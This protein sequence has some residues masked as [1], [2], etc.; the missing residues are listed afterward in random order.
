MPKLKRPKG[1]S[2]LYPPA[3]RAELFTFLAENDGNKSK[4]SRKLGIPRCTIISLCKRYAHEMQEQ[5]EVVR[6]SILD[7]AIADRELAMTV[8]RKA[9]NKAF[10]L[11]GDADDLKGLR[12]SDIARSMDLLDKMIRAE[13][14]TDAGQAAENNP[15]D[16]G[17]VS[18]AVDKLI[19]DSAEDAED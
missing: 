13:G 4:A 2:D 7:Q 14:V 12:T 1:M 9:L 3:K 10:E 11:I 6:A 18:K 17:E 19:A 8:L 5:K 15:K 16:E